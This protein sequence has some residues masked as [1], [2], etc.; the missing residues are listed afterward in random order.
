MPTEMDK[1]TSGMVDPTFPRSW[2]YWFQRIGKLIGQKLDIITGAGGKIPVINA[3]GELEASDLVAEQVVQGQGTSTVGHVAI[4]AN[5]TATLIEDAGVVLPEPSDTVVTETAFGQSS[6][7]GT[8]DDYSRGDH[9][10][11]TPDAPCV[12][13][14]MLVADITAPTELSAI[15][16][17]EAGDSALAYDGAGKFTLYAYA[18][19]A[20]GASPFVVSGWVAIAGEY[21]QLTIN[22]HQL[23]VD[24]KPTEPSH[25]IRL[26]D[27]TGPYWP[28]EYWPAEY[29]PAGYWP[30]MRLADISG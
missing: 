22:T 15:A 30:L 18:A 23:L 13:Q 5:T 14:K 16:D 11:G 19:G 10:H 24:T 3:D 6:T 2:L 12:L 8:S 17:P 29:W 1:I 26:E 9:T 20:T 4:F 25:V 27:L 7:A 21:S 28:D